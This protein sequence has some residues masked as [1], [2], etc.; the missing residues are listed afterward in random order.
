MPEERGY[1]DYIIFSTRNAVCAADP[2]FKD[3]V[4]RG[5]SRSDC[6]GGKWSEMWPGSP[7]VQAAFGQACID[8]VNA[9][10]PNPSPDG[11]AGMGKDTALRYFSRLLPQATPATA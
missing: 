2:Q 10:Y 1:G 6:V 11:R 9:D 7:E 3:F 8:R 5:H 4:G